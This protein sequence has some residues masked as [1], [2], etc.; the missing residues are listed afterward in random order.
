MTDLT[1][2]L[3]RA[4][5][6]AIHLVT[7]EEVAEQD[8]PSLGDLA[9]C[10]DLF[11]DNSEFIHAVTI[12]RHVGPRRTTGFSLGLD[13][14]D[15]PPR[16]AL[17]GQSLL[18]DK[19]NACIGVQSSIRRKNRTNRCG[20]HE[21]IAFLTAQCYRMACIDK[22]H[23]THMVWNHTQDDAENE[24]SHRSLGGS[25]CAG[26]GMPRRLPGRAADCHVRGSYARQTIG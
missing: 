24:A 11:F 10:L 4:A 12:F 6:A 18:I 16:M 22:V 23:S 5:D 1:I 14:T 17:L 15:E 7:H 25:G 19:P 2:M 20:R 8:L 21:V 13:S 9:Y 3:L 26:C